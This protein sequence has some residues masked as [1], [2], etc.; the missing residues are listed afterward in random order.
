MLLLLKRLLVTMVAIATAISPS[1]GNVIDSKRP[2]D[3]DFKVTSYIYA[4]RVL[5]PENLHEEDFDIITDLFIFD[6]LTFDRDGNVQV[7]DDLLVP[8]LK[9]I[10]AAIGDRDVDISVVALGPHYNGETDS[11]E[12]LMVKQ[13][14]EYTHAFKSGVLED[15]I[16]DVVEKYDFDGVEFDY[17]YPFNIVNWK[18]FNDFLVSMDKK[19]GDKTLGIAISDWDMKLDTNAIN[20]VDHFELMLYDI[21]DENGLHSTTAHAEEL[22]KKAALMGIPKNKV[23]FGLPF[24]ARPTDHGAYWYDYV[25][26]ADKLD[27]NGFYHDDNNGKDFWFNTPDVIEEK[28]AYALEKGF[29]G[30]M[31]WHYTCDFA[32]SDERS[33]LGGVS[34]AIE[35]YRDKAEIPETD[36]PQTTIPEAESTTKAP[37]IDEIQTT[38]VQTEIKESTTVESSKE[39]TEN[40]VDTEKQEAPDTGAKSTIALA[41]TA[42]AAGAALIVTKKKKVF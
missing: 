29:R 4:E 17:E 40:E 19:L 16:M 10:R 39:E 38:E 24:Y 34:R 21:Y 15:N 37:V 41:A 9:N 36:V 22:S 23:D 35:E 28:T 31:I 30:V 12:D 3:R 13:G 25:S 32:S 7:R 8:A 6:C 18:H 14:Q 26:F 2:A 1:L 5:N 42:L 33:L 20:A 11:W 27:E